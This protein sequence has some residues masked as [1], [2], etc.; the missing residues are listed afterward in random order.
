PPPPPPPK[1]EQREPAYEQHPGRPLE[2]QQN[3][4]LREGKEAG[5]MRD[6]EHAPHTETF[7]AKV[8][9][10]APAPK[11]SEPPREAP[12]NPSERQPK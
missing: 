5:P 12:R 11:P 9:E 10:H 6:A 3:Q 4:N 2:P 8:A 7:N 1:Y